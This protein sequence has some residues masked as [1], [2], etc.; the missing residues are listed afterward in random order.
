MMNMSRAD[1]VGMPISQRYRMVRWRVD[2]Q[3]Q[4]NKR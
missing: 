3:N 1:V 4:A 2:M